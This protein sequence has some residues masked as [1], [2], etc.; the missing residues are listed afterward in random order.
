[1]K[2]LGLRIGILG[3]GNVGGALGRAWARAGHQIVFGSRDPNSPKIRQLLE[4]CGGNARVGTMSE[5]ARSA[6]VVAVAL[7]WDSAKAV[8]EAL[9]LRGKI[10]LDCMN[11]LLPELAGLELG[12]TTSGGE[13]VAGCYYTK[14]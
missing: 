4:G 6:S 3:T 9:D 10:V 2:E 7:P 14:P 11:P 5:A 13:Q 1:M 12:T 8:I